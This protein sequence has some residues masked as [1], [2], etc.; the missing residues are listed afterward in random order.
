MEQT[1]FI[2]T[3]LNILSSISNISTDTNKEYI[4][5]YKGEIMFGKIVGQKIFL[6]KVPE[7]VKERAMAKYKEL[8]N[9]NDETGTKT[10]QYL[11]GLLKIPFGIY[12]C[13]PILNIIH[14][15]NLDFSKLIHKKN[16][17]IVDTITKKPKYTN[18]EISKYLEQIRNQIVKLN[19]KP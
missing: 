9:K 3:I 8:K 4:G 1:E 12:K 18:I 11:E 5:L 19:I 7:N 10:K 13:E 17:F 16:E 2:K 6:L 15:I 14:Q